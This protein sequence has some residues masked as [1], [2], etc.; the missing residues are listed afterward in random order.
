MNKKKWLIGGLG[1]LALAAALIAAFN[2][3]VDPFGVFGDRFF[4]WYSYNMTQETSVAKI[5]YLER[6]HEEYDSYILGS[7]SASAYLPETLE[8]YLSLIHISFRHRFDGINN[9]GACMAR[10]HR[11]P[12]DAPVRRGKTRR[13]FYF[14][15]E[16]RS[17]MIRRQPDSL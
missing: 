12:E 15:P 8:Q 1:L 14:F 17:G 11:T 6:H 9:A 3:I 13:L 16:R 4:N 10:I 5:A 2:I 7:G